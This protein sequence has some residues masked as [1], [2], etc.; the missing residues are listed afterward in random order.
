MVQKAMR[1]AAS[2]QNSLGPKGDWLEVRGEVLRPR[3][4]LSWPL[5][6]WVAGESEEAMRRTLSA[7]GPENPEE[8]EIALSLKMWVPL[9]LGPAAEQK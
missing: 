7:R 8:K 1:S 9:S 3:T 6:K 2:T 4:A 5:A